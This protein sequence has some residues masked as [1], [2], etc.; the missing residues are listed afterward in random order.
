MKKCKC[1]SPLLVYLGNVLACEICKGKIWY[2]I[3]Y[4]KKHLI[5]KEKE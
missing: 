1:D 2:D 4:W 3:E 5:K